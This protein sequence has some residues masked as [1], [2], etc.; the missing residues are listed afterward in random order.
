MTKSKATS[1]SRSTKKAIPVDTGSPLSVKVGE[2]V[3]ERTGDGGGS[4]RPTAT[5]GGSSG[6]G[7]SG[8]SVG[9]ADCGSGRVDGGSNFTLPPRVP[10]DKDPMGTDSGPDSRQRSDAVQISKKTISF[11]TSKLSPEGSFPPLISPTQN[12]KHMPWLQVPVKKKPVKGPKGRR[13]RGHSEAE[14]EK[15]LEYAQMIDDP[16]WR[17]LLTQMSNNKFP[18]GYIF[19]TGYLIYKNNTK[20]CKKLQIPDNHSEAVSAIID[21]FRETGGYR[22]NRDQS[23]TVESNKLHRQSTQTKPLAECTWSEITSKNI[24]EM[25]I[26]EYIDACCQSMKLNSQQRNQMTTT[27]NLGFILGHFSVNSVVFEE[28]SVKSI[29]GLTYSEDTGKFSFDWSKIVKT[30]KPKPR[31]KFKSDESLFFPID[32]QKSRSGFCYL[33]AW[34]KL[35]RSMEKIAAVKAA[36]RST[37]SVSE[38][39]D[40]V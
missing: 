12:V 13:G 36:D 32:N 24:R 27:V 14:F 38:S 31:P 40:E 6:S 21:F 34:C 4:G 39:Q 8:G 11:K 2:R 3:G 15:F 19:K 20:K 1:R 28:G 26:E 17:T 16:Y 35:I 30:Y 18:K 10:S 5:G 23:L 9:R 22:S 37:E 25:L 29:S 33:T 7:G